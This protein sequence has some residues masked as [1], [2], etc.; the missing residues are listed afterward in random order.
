MAFIYKAFNGPSPT[1]AALV[2]V[3]TGTAIKT[4]MQIATPSTESLRIVEWGISFDGSA[5]ATPIEVELIDVNVGA[6]VTAYAAADIVKL[7]APN[8]VGTLMTLGTSAS[9][10][11]ASAEGSVTGARL[12][13][14]QLVA[15]TSQYVMQYPLGREP[16]VA[17]SRF[18]RIRVTAPAAVNCTCYICWEE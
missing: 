14:Y 9:G 5:A 2:K 8:D 11:T 15:P 13:D 12:L 3:T 7:N 16:A 1:S 4:L 6:T 10:Y 17:A 18:L